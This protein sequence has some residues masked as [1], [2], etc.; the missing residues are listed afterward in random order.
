MKRRCWR[1]RRIE[2][3]HSSSLT[4]IDATRPE[5]EGHWRIHSFL[6]EA[7]PPSQI[8]FM[9]S[10][11]ILASL[12]DTSTVINHAIHN[13]LKLHSELYSKVLRAGPNDIFLI[14]DH[15][16]GVLTIERR[17]SIWTGT[18]AAGCLYWSS[19]TE[20]KRGRNSGFNIYSLLLLHTIWVQI[21]WDTIKIAPHKSYIRLDNHIP[22]RIY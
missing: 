19:H 2:H 15:C 9:S 4:N 16:Y 14:F 6:L 1:W 11:H 8:C 22:L 18:P 3:S 21:N 20:S 17:L 12:S 7:A 13:Y 10:F 5:Q